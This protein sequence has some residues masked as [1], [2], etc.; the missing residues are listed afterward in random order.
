[1]S[2]D[3]RQAPLAQNRQRTMGTW[4]RLFV[5]CLGVLVGS[6]M[7]VAANPTPAQLFYVPFPEG[8]LLQ[9]LQAIELGG[10]SA[11]PTDPVTTLIS[12]AAVA[13]GTIIYYDQW[14]NGYDPDIANPT[15]LYS[16]GNPG[17][18]QIWG[19]GDP[20]NGAPPGVP[21][22]LINAGTV[23]VLSNPIDTTNPL[24]IDFDGRDKVAATKTIA[25]TRTGFA[26]GPNTLLAGA[27][28]VFDTSNWGTNHLSPVGTDIPDATDHQMFEY[29]SLAV[30]AGEG[31]A[32][33]QVDADADGSFETTV[34]LDEGEGYFVNGGVAVGGRVVA[35]RPVQV[36]LLTGDIAS[37]YESRD[38]ALLPTT[39]WSTDYYTPV[40][41][42]P[43]AQSIAGTATTV[44][45]YNPGATALTVNYTTRDGGG[46]LTT[47]PLSVPG[48]PSGGYL[49]QVIPD[50]FGGRF[51]AAT[52]FYAFSTTNSTD[53]NTSGNQAWDW[54]FTLIPEDSLTPQVL[55]GLGIGRDPT[56]P[57]NPN[58]NGN[59][60]WLTPVGNGDTPVTVYVDFDAD[61]STG[62]LTD[63]NGNKYDVAYSLRELDRAKVYDTTDRNQTGLLAYVLT[64]GVKLAAAW[65]QD[66]TVASAGAPGLDVGTGI[67]PLPLFSVGKNGTLAADNDGDGF[68]SPGDVL[69]YTIAINNISRA[70]VPDVL[71]RDNLPADTTYV[72]GSTF[73][74]NAS[75]VTTPI[76]DDGS[77][78]PFPLDGSG[79][80]LDP[81]TA[82]PVGG[83]YQVTFK[84][85]IDAFPDLVPGTTEIVNSCS[86][87][88]VGVTL[89]CRDTTPLFGR[90]GDFVWVD[91]DGDGV[92]DGGAE[93]GIGGVQVQL[94]L[95]A[96]GNGIIDGGDTVLETQTTTS[97]GGYLFTGVPPGDYIVNVVDSTVPPTY[98]LTTANDPTAVPLAGGQSRLDVDF[99]YK[100]PTPTT[101]TTTTTTSTSTT[102]TTTST[103]TTTRP[104][105]TT[106]TSTTSTTTTTRPTTTSTTTTTTTTTTTS[107]LLGQLCNC[108]E[109]PFLFERDARINNEATVDATVGVRTFLG[110]LRVS[111]NVFMPDGTSLSAFFVEV[112]NDSNVSQVF[113]DQLQRGSNAVIRNG[114]GPVSL[115]LTPPI[116]TLPEYTCGTTPVLATPGQVTGPIA[117][118]D[119]GLVRVPNGATL[120]LSEGV[121]TMCGIKMGRGAKIVAEGAVVL[122]ITGSLQVGNESYFG[123]DTGA[124]PIVAY[125]G[126]TKVR[127]GA[128]ALAVARIVAPNARA[129]FGRDS[130][131]EGCIC[132]DR[133]KSDKRITLECREN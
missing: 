59:P 113:A 124:P 87:S 104:S 48:G 129:A 45:L 80:V 76:P 66:P 54:G 64:P 42:P 23:I 46:N 119:Y 44:W 57:T 19:D 1:M 73:F 14:E 112:G 75:N 81:V 53:T 36:T 37:S 43:A 109:I 10:P 100:P 79:R 97:G 114:V 70:P 133:M 82:L 7:A 50:G 111:Q 51:S 83:T 2:I 125:V 78:T 110:R 85:V 126:G 39:L 107:T 33:V 21:S 58:E 15:N 89:P 101:T 71:V 102:T 108:D 86:A 22:D 28:E 106:T 35:D 123:P 115:P 84:V 9:G 16:G 117:P 4:R 105:T 95:D 127:L 12:L 94:I 13:D 26:T 88:A 103:T 5:A 96:N 131:L 47:V 77:G 67:P 52:P 74:T 49:P 99:G 38:S 68:V 24:A 132:S 122:Q 72:P 56:S 120:R 40:S 41:T 3:G 61:P 116:C 27:T 32:T 62:P 91:L 17:G 90:I 31:G 121:Y 34:P 18:T 25:M 60:V 69:L 92:Q 55:I 29:T 6:G 93:V 63:P 65:G 20:S 128:N 30:M 11:A 98:T 118:G 130:R 8:Q